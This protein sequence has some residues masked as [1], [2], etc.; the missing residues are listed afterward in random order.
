MSVSSA[1]RHK[2]DLHHETSGGYITEIDGMRAIAVM[3]VFIF[4]LNKN[5]IPGGFVG[6]D[7]FFVISGFLISTLIIAALDAGRFSYFQFYQRRIARIAPAATVTVVAAL[8]AGMLLYDRQDYASLGANA[9]AAMLSVMNFKQLFEGGYFKA[10]VDAQPLIHYWS[11]SVEEQFYVFFPVFMH[12][13]ARFWRKN[14]A[15]ILIG[16]CVLGYI[17]SIILTPRMPVAAYY[18]LHTRAW[19]L[20]VGAALAVLKRDGKVAGWPAPGLRMNIGLILVCLGMIFARGDGFPGWIA[21]LPVGGAVL[22]LSAAGGQAAAEPGFVARVLS[23][24]VLV[25]IGKISFSLYLW[26]W[27]V[28]SF[29]N[30][31]LYDYPQYFVYIGMVI[32][33]FAAAILSY[34]YV[35]TPSRKY[36]NAPGHMKFAFAMFVA[37]AAIISLAG[38][39]IRK[40]NYLSAPEKS[41]ASGGIVVNGDKAPALLLMGDSQG[42]MYAHDIAQIARARSLRVNLLAA[43][44]HNE[45]PEEDGTQWPKVEQYLH[46]KHFALIIIAQAWGAKLPADGV[47]HM[48]HALDRLLPYADRIMLIGQLPNVPENASRMAIATG[49]VHLPVYEPEERL[50]QRLR[51]QSVL[52]RLSGPKVTVLEIA[53]LMHNADGS[54]RLIA[55]NGR[56]AYHDAGH[57]SSSGQLI[58]H[59]RLDRA[60]A[61]ALKGT[62]AESTVH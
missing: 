46:G 59:E 33:S 58:L 31:S 43:A 50:R 62:G 28:F 7:V 1:V 8:L 17:A 49:A 21:I 24:P 40:S 48:Q 47:T 57:L 38:W 36:L 44:A 30:Y 25:F 53:D 39:S 41:I 5:Y 32:L 20:L 2:A 12:V 22:M 29:L 37:T 56:I 34:Y 51:A 11:L 61:D 42:A 3:S 10:S 45:L 13:V 26:H 4:H 60:I 23:W 9:A 52:A 35:E 55:P 54:L 15:A 27:V 19:E 14:C 18:L 6:V 16:L